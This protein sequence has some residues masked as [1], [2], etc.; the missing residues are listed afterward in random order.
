M[1]T[2]DASIH[3]NG[4]YR[5]VDKYTF[6]E[7]SFGNSVKA[8]NLPGRELSSKFGCTKTVKRSTQRD[9]G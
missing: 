5:V 2:T 4:S 8:F 6:R 9:K 1:I 3:K 7:G